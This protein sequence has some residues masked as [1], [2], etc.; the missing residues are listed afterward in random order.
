MFIKIPDLGD[1]LLARRVELGISRP[2]MAKSLR[3]SPE[4]LKDWELK[5]TF[6]KEE[7]LR[8]VASNYRLEDEIVS[9]SF[10]NSKAAWRKLTM[11]RRGLKDAKD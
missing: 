11:V 4:T 8:D 9:N 10:F 2:F 3:V 7:R 1:L 5:E 6:P